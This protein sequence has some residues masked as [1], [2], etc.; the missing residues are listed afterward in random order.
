M[1]DDVTIPREDLMAFFDLA[2][3]SMDFGSGFWEES[4]IHVAR[5]VAVVIG[6]DP[7]EATP[8]NDR[9]RYPH[10]FVARVN[11]YGDGPHC[12]VCGQLEHEPVVADPGA[13][14]VA[15]DVV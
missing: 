12:E 13:T 8:F 3:N 1:N 4:D 6:V 10:V 5:R 9:R 11:P 7:M 14:A 15:G 2:V